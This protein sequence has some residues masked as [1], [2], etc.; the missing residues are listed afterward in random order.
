MPM[1][2]ENEPIAR[3]RAAASSRAAARS[4]D[5][6]P[7][8]PTLESVLRGRR[9]VRDFDSRPVARDVLATTV[10]TAAAF[11]GATFGRHAGPAPSVYLAA[12]RVG[13]LSQGLYEVRELA[14]LA[15]ARAVPFR[16]IDALADA[17]CPAQAIFV[18]C[19]DIAAYCHG[20]GDE[21]Y[22][23]LLVRCSAFGYAL[24]MA[25]RAEG[26]E[27][28]VFGRAAREI[29]SAIRRDSGSGLRH[30]FTVAVGYAQTD[31]VGQQTGKAAAR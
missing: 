21:G 25:A 18:I 5:W 11:D 13:D 4:H 23:G 2:D 29:T 9:S 24:W 28:A 7:T 17:Y 1:I 14:G 10:R 15:T 27:G 20:R 8:A 3:L 12:H 6:A 30:L 26:L 16:E 19:G 22:R 31:Q